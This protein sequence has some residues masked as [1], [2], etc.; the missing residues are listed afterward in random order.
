MGWDGD[1]RDSYFTIREKIQSQQHNNVL[2]DKYSTTIN[3]VL[4]PTSHSC[5]KR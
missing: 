1:G 5:W 2:I 3:K 4:S